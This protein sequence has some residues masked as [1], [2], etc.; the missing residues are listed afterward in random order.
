MCKSQWM[1]RFDGVLSFVCL[2]LDQRR[3]HN[4]FTKY[5]TN[6]SIF[7]GSVTESSRPQQDICTLIPEFTF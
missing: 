5:E 2:F 1:S 4:C 6:F 3:K 7:L